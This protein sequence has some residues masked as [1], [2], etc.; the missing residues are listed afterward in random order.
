M[1][2]YTGINITK[3]NA[4]KRDIQTYIEKI[5]AIFLQIDINIENINNN[6]SIEALDA[7]QLKTKYNVLKENYIIIEKNLN[8]Y[9]TDINNFAKYYANS[10]KAIAAQINRD[11]SKL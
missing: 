4:L 6:L 7:V 2:T 11:I 1:V 8:K 3:V 9:I 5:H 10:D